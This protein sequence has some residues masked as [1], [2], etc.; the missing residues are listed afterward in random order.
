VGLAARD[1]ATHQVGL[2]PMWFTGGTWA[3]HH[4]TG[5]DWETQ[6]EGILCDHMC[7]GHAGEVT[8][9]APVTSQTCLE[10]TDFLLSPLFQLPEMYGNHSLAASEILTAGFN[11]SHF[12]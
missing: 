8:I 7:L 11:Y 4:N 10:F 1:C 2:H 12:P 6:F 3:T 9:S 5:S